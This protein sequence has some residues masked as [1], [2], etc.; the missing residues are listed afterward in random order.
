M[1]INYETELLSPGQEE[2]IQDHQAV[3][4]NKPSGGGANPISPDTRGS[5]DSGDS[6]IEQVRQ[7]I[8]NGISPLQFKDSIKVANREMGNRAL[9]R[10]VRSLSSQ[11]INMDNHAIATAGLKGAGRPLTHGKAIQQA[12]GHH[13]ISQMREYIGP[14]AQASVAALGAQ[15]YSS[16]GRV[17]FAGSPDL[18]TQAHEAAHAIQQTALGSG[19]QLLGGLGAEDD[20]YEQHADAVAHAVVQGESAEALLDQLADGPT[21]VVPGMAGIAGP[22]QM[23]K[24]KQHK[25]NV[26]KD[27]INEGT[28]AQRKLRGLLSRSGRHELL[29]L[30]YEEGSDAEKLHELNE[31]FEIALAHQLEHSAVGIARRMAKLMGGFQSFEEAKTFVQRNLHSPLEHTEIDV[32]SR[33]RTNRK[34]ITTV[35]NLSDTRR[36]QRNGHD[37]S[38]RNLYPAMMKF[39]P[40]RGFDP[41][42]D[43]YLCGWSD[44]IE[45]VNLKLEWLKEFRAQVERV[46]PTE[47]NRPIRKHF[48]KV[49]NTVKLNHMLLSQIGYFGGSMEFKAGIEEDLEFW[50]Y[51]MS[52]KTRSPKNS[53]LYPAPKQMLPYK[54]SEKSL[55]PYLNQFSISFGHAEFSKAKHIPERERERLEQALEKFQQQGGDDAIQELNKLAGTP[56]HRGWWDLSDLLGR[57]DQYADGEERRKALYTNL[58]RWS[59]SEKDYDEVAHE[60]PF[61]GQNLQK[62]H[63]SDIRDPRLREEAATSGQGLKTTAAN[64]Q[65]RAHVTGR[66]ANILLTPESATWAFRKKLRRLDTMEKFSK[67]YGEYVEEIGKDRSRSG[68]MK[69]ALL[70]SWRQELEE[71][72]EQ[73]VWNAV[74]KVRDWYEN[75][76]A[77][78]KPM[79][80]GPSG[81][82]LG[83][84]NLYAHAYDQDEF[85]ANL[86]LEP[87]FASKPTLEEARV[88]MLASL[89]GKK[90]HHSYDEVMTS[91][92]GI[93]T[94]FRGD[95][96]QNNLKYKY[97]GNYADVF[98]TEIDWLREAA[99]QARAIV[100]DKYR[101][102]EEYKSVLLQWSLHLFSNAGEMQRR[103]PGPERLEVVDEEEEGH[104]NRRKTLKDVAFSFALW[105]VMALVMFWQLLSHFKDSPGD[106]WNSTNSSWNP[107]D[108]TDAHWDTNLTNTTDMP[109]AQGLSPMFWVPTMLLGSMVLADFYM[110]KREARTASPYTIRTIARLG[111]QVTSKLMSAGLGL[112]LTYVT[113]NFSRDFSEHPEDAFATAAFREAILFTLNNLIVVLLPNLLSYYFSLLA[114][115][116]RS[117]CLEPRTLQYDNDYMRRALLAHA[118]RSIGITSLV[119]GLQAGGQLSSNPYDAEVIIANFMLHLITELLVDRIIISHE[120]AEK[121]YGEDARQTMLAVKSRA[122]GHP[123]WSQKPFQYTHFGRDPKLQTWGEKVLWTFTTSADHWLFI[124]ALF[125]IFSFTL[126]AVITQKAGRDSARAVTALANIVIAIF[127]SYKRIRDTGTDNADKLPPLL[128][129]HRRGWSYLPA[130]IA[131]VRAARRSDHEPDLE[132][133]EEQRVVGGE[134]QRIVESLR[135]IV[136]QT[137]ELAGGGDGAFYERPNMSLGDI[138]DMAAA[139]TSTSQAGIAEVSTTPD[140]KERAKSLPPENSQ[141]D[142]MLASTLQFEE[143]KQWM[144]ETTRPQLDELSPENYIERTCLS[145]DLLAEHKKQNF[146]ASLEPHRL[147]RGVAHGDRLQCFLDTVYQWTIGDRD[148]HIRPDVESILRHELDLAAEGMVEFDVSPTGLLRKIAGRLNATI[149]VYGINANTGELNPYGSVGDGGHHYHLLHYGRHFEPLWPVS[150]PMVQ[151]PV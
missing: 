46:N 126:W 118:G 67:V 64:S 145:E 124:K 94:D 148:E 18:Y 39:F 140:I 54:T 122:I 63:P 115:K 84:L 70:E 44:D 40:D 50:V 75:A 5:P 85:A 110:L 90:E 26:R 129:L 120:W 25:K 57:I 71:Q 132:R 150:T 38:E 51:L 59:W 144:T 147:E 65:T 34:N 13:D 89:I 48:R 141:L 107:L 93:K 101:D 14:A 11:N 21:T 74:D 81:H 103:V 8:I 113:L 137:S 86:G 62:L 16:N 31:Q 7:G 36:Q 114:S 135:P 146:R 12:F 104:T 37:Y 100:T 88:V 128:R 97:P 82:T 127:I 119:S 2:Q 73:V 33:R 20:K 83:Y 125:T 111:P 6:A 78:H 96:R 68:R 30:L 99:E 105:L 56:K 134:L 22:V 95:H 69:D 72:R 108:E 58:L 52:A 9:L 29:E 66:A 98:Y 53:L 143:F 149:H 123:S 35:L 87:E 76:R 10:F 28:F 17:A 151:T 23:I 45:A 55:L 60:N 61:Y 117:N 142:E 80:A 79:Y 131:Q 130:A 24:E 47:K 112:G 91:S 92:H 102:R 106:S 109:Q 3:I 27:P 136:E 43:E 1:Y 19:L 49:Y 41:V 4:T 133:G 15:A 121:L 138:L 139:A 116:C 77:T 32:H 42:P